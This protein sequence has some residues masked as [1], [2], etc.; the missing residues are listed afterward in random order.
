MST[1][2]LS[3]A[4]SERLGVALVIGG[5][6]L[7]AVRSPLALLAYLCLTAGSLVLLAVALNRRDAAQ[8]AMQLTFVMINAIGLAL[9]IG[10][11]HA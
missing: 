5:A 7:L 2:F 3:V 10:S 4:H 8:A 6:L 9:A 11:A 1:H